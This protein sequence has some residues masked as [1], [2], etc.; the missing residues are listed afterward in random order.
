MNLKYIKD[1]NDLILFCKTRFFTQY[2]T[3][4]LNQRQMVPSILTERT[5]MSD[6]LVYSSV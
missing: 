5:G 2:D 3:M 1:L 4:N 6:N